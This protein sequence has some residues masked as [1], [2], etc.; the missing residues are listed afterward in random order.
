MKRLTISDFKRAILAL[1][2]A[3]ARIVSGESAMA[4]GE[5]EAL[6][7]V[8]V[9]V[10]ELLD[11]PTARRCYAWEADG[12]AVAVLHTPSVDSPQAAVSSA[13]AAD[14]RGLT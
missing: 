3:R 6:R 2:G 10:F 8:P 4:R 11:H 13:R 12:R 14:A 5:G 7:E 1:H 9:L